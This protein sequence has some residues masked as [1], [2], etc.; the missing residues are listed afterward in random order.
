LRQAGLIAHEALH[1]VFS[2]LDAA[3]LKLKRGEL[4]DENSL[5]VD[6][7]RMMFKL[8]FWKKLVYTTNVEQ[9]LMLCYAF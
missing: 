8:G 1:N 2:L 6:C 3:C 7:L 5:G 4:T 9:S